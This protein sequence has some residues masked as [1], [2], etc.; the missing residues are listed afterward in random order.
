MEGVRETL[1]S[2]CVRRLVRVTP[3]R[4]GPPA[5]HKEPDIA[6]RKLD[7]VLTALPEGSVAVAIGVFIAGVAAFGFLSLSAPAPGPRPD[8]DP[9]APWV[10]R[11]I[12]RPGGVLPL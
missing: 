5:A 6:N 2:G 11:V 4:T 9:A 3:S 7:S 10:L 8:S 12:S 1:E